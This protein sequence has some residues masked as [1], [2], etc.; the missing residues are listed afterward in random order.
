MAWPGSVQHPSQRHRLAAAEVCHL[1]EIQLGAGEGVRAA[2][3]PVPVFAPPG[4]W[5]AG[6]LDAAA[7]TLSAGRGAI[8]GTTRVW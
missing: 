7:A 4:D 1:R 3:T 8:L 5:A 2:W 6:L